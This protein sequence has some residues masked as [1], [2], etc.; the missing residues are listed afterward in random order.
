MLNKHLHRELYENYILV[1]VALSIY[2]KKFK[3]GVFFLQVKKKTSS[4]SENCG[5]EFK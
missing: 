5:M 1:H 4:H 2:Q 3:T